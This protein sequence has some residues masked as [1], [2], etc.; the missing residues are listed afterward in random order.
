MVWFPGANESP[1]LYRKLLFLA[2][3]HK[4]VFL[5]RMISPLEGDRQPQEEH[6]KPQEAGCAVA[7]SKC[8]AMGPRMTCWDEEYITIPQGDQVH[9]LF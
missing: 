1:C 8:Q 7:T 5:P 4:P 3:R 2:A 6:L 9:P